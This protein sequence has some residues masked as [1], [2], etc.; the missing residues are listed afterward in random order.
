VQKLRQRARETAERLSWSKAFDALERSLV[1]FIG[2]R[3][4]AR[5]DGAPTA[6]ATD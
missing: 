5:P 2:T 6:A 1:K 3:A 4:R